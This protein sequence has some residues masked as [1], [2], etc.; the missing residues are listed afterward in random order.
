MA[1]GIRNSS[2]GCRCRRGNA[3]GTSAVGGPPVGR[4]C[5]MPDVCTVTFRCL[6]SIAAQESTVLGK[7]ARSRRPLWEDISGPATAEGGGITGVCLWLWGMGGG[8][9]TRLGHRTYNN[10]GVWH[11]P[12]VETATSRGEE[13]MCGMG[14]QDKA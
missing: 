4:D 2:S 14:K 12:A 11:V 1:E 7:H 5:Y 9:R 8:N 3:V 10:R 13:A 6:L